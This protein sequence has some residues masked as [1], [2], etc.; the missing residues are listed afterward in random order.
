MCFPFF[1]FQTV[2]AFLPSMLAKNHGHI[3][4][5]NS[6]LGLMGVGGAT[7]YCASKFGALGLHEALSFEVAREGK[8]GVFLT[9]VHP[10][11]VDT[12]MFAGATTR[13]VVM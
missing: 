6:M 4:S 9:T 2:K 5:I 10:Y 13:S 11:H 8:N 7:E 1:A 12:D 3:V